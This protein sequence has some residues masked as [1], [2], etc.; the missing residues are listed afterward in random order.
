MEHYTRTLH[1]SDTRQ[2]EFYM[3]FIFEPNLRRHQRENRQ[4]CL[5]NGQK[6][7]E[8]NIFYTITTTRKKGAWEVFLSFP[9]WLERDNDDDDDDDDIDDDDQIKYLFL[10]LPLDWLGRRVDEPF[11]VKGHLAEL[12]GIG[13][14]PSLQQNLC[15]RTKSSRLA[16][17]SNIWQYLQFSA[18]LE[19]LPILNIGHCWMLTN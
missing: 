11:L 10:H 18:R 8:L 7:L 15:L 12:A 3:E 19:Y 14:A 9:P 17:D 5:S 6:R 1:L 16:A 13:D 2:R 4:C